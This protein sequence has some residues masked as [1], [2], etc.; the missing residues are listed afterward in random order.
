MQ[1]NKKLP[2]IYDQRENN[3]VIQDQNM[4]MFNEPLNKNIQVE[5]I[6]KKKINHC[7][8]SFNEDSNLIKSVSTL[9]L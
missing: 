6:V 2:I 4:V 5:I 8:R 9:Y 1:E 7:N 3:L